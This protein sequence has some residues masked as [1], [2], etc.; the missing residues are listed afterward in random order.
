MAGAAAERVDLFHDDGLKLLTGEGMNIKRILSEI[1]KLR[2]WIQ[3]HQNEVIPDGSKTK[4]LS[5][6]QLYY[7]LTERLF[8]EEYVS[9]VEALVDDYLKLPEGKLTSSRSKQVCLNW[10]EALKRREWNQ[11]E[12]A[13]LAQGGERMTRRYIIADMNEEDHTFLLMSPDPNSEDFLEDVT[14]VPELAEELFQ[15][16]RNAESSGTS[17]STIYVNVQAENDVIVSYE[18]SEVSSP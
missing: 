16:V 8:E 1:N 5:T 14:V 6:L 7:K 12:A 3:K 10:L 15:H 17:S 4:L 9:Q 13:S 18:L 11:E 2:R